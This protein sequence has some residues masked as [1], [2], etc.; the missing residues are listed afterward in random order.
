MNRMP[1]NDPEWIK[2]LVS[3]VVGMFTGLVADPIRSLIQNRIEA[4]KL[5]N[6]IIWDTATLSETAVR[7]HDGKLEAWKFWLGVEL[8]ALDTTGRRT[9]TCSTSTRNSPC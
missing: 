9:A 5:R 7:V 3:A 2:I 6:A 8:P 1:T 4:R